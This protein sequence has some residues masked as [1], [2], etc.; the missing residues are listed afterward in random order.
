M[1]ERLGLGRGVGAAGAAVV[2]GGVQV[3]GTIEHRVGE[4]VVVGDVG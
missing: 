3:F 4:V 2:G 1:R